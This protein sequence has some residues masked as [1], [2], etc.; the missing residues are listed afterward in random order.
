MKRNVL[1][2]AKEVKDAL[3]SKRPVVSLESTIISH[4]LPYPQNINMAN[5]VEATL[6][7][8]GVVPATCAFLNGQ[9]HIG[10]TQSE[11]LQFAESSQSGK[12]TKVSRRDIGYVM[13][14]KLNGG[15]TIA[16]TMIL[17][18]Y[19]GIK[20]FATGGLGGVHRDMPGELSMDISADLTELGRTPVS[21]I[22]A[23]PKSILDISKTLEFLETQGVFVGTYNEDNRPLNKLKIPGFYCRESKVSSPF[24]F[25]TFEEA[26][27]IVFNQNL[28]GLQS[29]NVFCIP[30]PKETA[31]DNDFISKVIDHAD[32]EARERGISGK[33]LTPFLLGQIA[34]RTKGKSIACNVSLVKNNAKAAA[35]IVKA[36]HRLGTVNQSVSAYTSSSSTTT[37]TRKNNR[38]NL[39]VVGSVALDTAAALSTNY[40]KHDSNIGTITNSVGG[41]GYNIAL[42]SSYI[43]NDTKFISRIGNDFAGETISNYLKNQLSSRL[44]IG[45]KNTAQYVSIH[46]NDKGDLN[47]ACADMSII[48]EPKFSEQVIET[49]QQ[50]KPKIVILDCNLSAQSMNNIVSYSNS[51]LD[52]NSSSSSYQQQYIIEPTSHVKAKRIGALDLSVFP[53]NQVK[54]VTPTIEELK[55]IF[56]SMSQQGKFN[57]LENWFPIIDAMNIDFQMRE[58]LM[59]FDSKNKFNF[60][61]SGVFQQ[62][63]HL[64][65]YFQNIIVKLGSRGVL[66]VS[67]VT[68]LQDLKSIPTTSKYKPMITITNDVDSK[69]GILI[70]YYPAPK[71][72]ENL[73]IVN[74]TGAGDTL[75]G[76]LAGKMAESLS[77]NELSGNWLDHEI[78]SSEQVWKKW[79]NIYKAQLASG[80]TLKCLKSVSE[81]IAKL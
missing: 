40:R 70:E 22:C 62:C 23:G 66:L 56:E 28:L 80:M 72:N 78:K 75:V 7:D 73:K 46:D 58:K 54:L 12:V 39:L 25:N 76:F 61:S 42:A 24:G 13:A 60:Q 18:H 69:I 32:K 77:N 37:T 19:A 45:D 41:V 55:S 63:F 33:Q 81:D 52:S 9:P 49:I 38:N 67:L 14:N 34:E 10:M 43:H 44:T 59:R 27:K 68:N 29:G 30:P 64:L 31:L 4:G 17:S 16:S 8:C 53:Y 26:A 2:I 15:T 79:E 35:E 1:R 6:R 5:E 65:P 50:D 71:E 47:I 74:V 57:C 11:L 3:N 51:N 48:E 20:F 21:V 36:Y